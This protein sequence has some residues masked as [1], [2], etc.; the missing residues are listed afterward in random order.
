MLNLIHDYI[1]H[2]QEYWADNKRQLTKFN[3]RKGS[4]QNTYSWSDNDLAFFILK[5]SEWRIENKL[6]TIYLPSNGSS[7]S[8]LIQ[9]IIANSVPCQPLGEAYIP[10]ALILEVRKLAPANQQ[11]FMESY[12]LLHTTKPQR[13][14]SPNIIVNT[15]HDARLQNYRSWT[16]SF[17]SIL[18]VRNPTDVAISRTFRKPEYRNY[19]GNEEMDDWAYLNLNIDRTMKFYEAALEVGYPEVMRFEDIFDAP[20]ITAKRLH[21]VLGDQVVNEHT[22]VKTIEQV[23]TSGK[24]TNKFSGKSKP[25]EDAYIDFANDRL[26]CLKTRMAY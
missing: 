23:A 4:I 20:H 16:A 12:N 13:L 26:S 3:A 15:A 10:K 24:D 6:R 22:L 11:I 21:S 18:I 9:E 17:Q 2:P 1:V 25:V 7:G 14:F 8:H 5:I 19:T